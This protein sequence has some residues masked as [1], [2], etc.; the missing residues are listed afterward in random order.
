V[1]D[2][3]FLE[4]IDALEKKIKILDAVVESLFLMARKHEHVIF[5]LYSP[6]YM[7]KMNDPTSDGTWKKG[8]ERK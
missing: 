7:Q 4:R 2:Y 3:D 8:S 6:K 5:E 1:K